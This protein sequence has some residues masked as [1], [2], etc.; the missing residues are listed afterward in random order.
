MYLV[1]N[2]YTHVVTMSVVGPYGFKIEEEMDLSIDMYLHRAE[3]KIY[4]YSN[5]DIAFN[6]IDR[7]A[8]S[9]E[10]PLAFIAFKVK[11]LFAIPKCV[12]ASRGPRL[13]LWRYSLHCENTLVAMDQG[14]KNKNYSRFCCVPGCRTDNKSE[15][16]FHKPPVKKDFAKEWLLSL[17]MT[18]FR[19]SM[20]A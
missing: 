10:Q 1:A 18:H 9:E 5:A 2:L 17:K 11:L 19:P 20:R 8:F 3:E 16:S 14:K 12:G 7:L 13:K 4:L 15:L 6:N